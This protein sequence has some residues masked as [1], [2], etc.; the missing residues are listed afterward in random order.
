MGKSLTVGWRSLLSFAR[1]ARFYNYVRPRVTED[2]IIEIQGG[3]HPLQEMVVESFQ[4]NDT[5]IKAGHEE[6]RPKLDDDLPTIQIL[7]GA[8]GCG[9][10]V[11][12]KQVALIVFMAQIGSF[13][14]AQSAR[15]SV[16]DQ[17][18]WSC[19]ANGASCLPDG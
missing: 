14:P 10:S 16:C 15:I 6:T 3:R 4:P 13:V 2:G 8:N 12:L 7:T 9:K 17:S 18:E 11:Y 1:A 5:H 19:R